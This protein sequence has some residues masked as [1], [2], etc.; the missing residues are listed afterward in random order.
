MNQT[1]ETILQH[2]SIRKFT[3]QPITQEQLNAVLDCAISASSSS[4]IQCVSIIRVTEP[5]KRTLLAD[6]AGGQAYVA[7]AA[8]FLVFCADFYRH[9]QIHPGAR[10]GYTEQTLIG[11]IDAALMAQNAMVAAESLGL[12][13]VY[14]GGIRNKPVEVS[15]LLSLPQHVLPL[16]GLCLGYPDQNPER[17]PRLPNALIVHQNSYQPEL[18]YQLLEQYDNEVREYY[19]TRTGGNKE[20]S[21]SEQITATLDKEARPFMKAFINNQGFSIK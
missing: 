11:A 3:D 18:D 7:S 14:I 2:R 21:W 4:F 19:R 5:E 10:L 20:M 6:Y 9:R 17:K 15:G 16:F 8:E 13:G 1:I 12:G